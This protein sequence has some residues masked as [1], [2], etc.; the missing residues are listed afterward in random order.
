MKLLLILLHLLIFPVYLTAQQV[1]ID[2]EF[3]GEGSILQPEKSSEINKKN[4]KNGF[5]IDN[6]STSYK[7]SDFQVNGLDVD[8]DDYEME[9]WL[10][11]LSGSDNYG[12]GLKWAGNYT[13]KNFVLIT[14]NQNYKVSY[15][16][17][18]K[19]SDFLAWTPNPKIVNSSK[20]MNKLKVIKIGHH[21]RILINDVTIYE[22]GFWRDFGN[23]F[24]IYVQDFM[25][26]Q[27]N[28]IKVIKYENK[29]INLVKDIDTSLK[30]EN[31]GEEW[32]GIY[33]KTQPVISPDGKTL[34]CINW[35]DPTNVGGKDDAN[36]V[37]YSTLGS[38]GKW[39]PL[40]NISKPIN[41]KSS[42]FVIACSPDNNMLVLANQ[43]DENGESNG[44]GMSISLRNSDGNFSIPVN[45][46]I[47][48]YK[49]KSG[50]VSYFIPTNNKTL[51]LGIESD[52]GFG[53]QDLHVSFLNN[54]NTWSEPL[55]MG[56]IIN[57]AGPDATPFLA[58]DGKTL[59]FSSA[60]HKGFGGYDIFV[61]RRLDD[62]WTNWSVPENLGANINTWASEIGYFMSAKGD[63]AYLSSNGDIHRIKN[64]AAI[65]PVILLFGKVLNNVT[66]K[67][68]AAQIKY[69]DLTE[70][71]EL[72]IAVSD[73]I[74]GE[75][76]IVLQKGKKYSFLA[77]KNGFYAV[78]ESIDLKDLNEYKEINRDLF[79]NPVEKGQSIRLN[80]LF[81]EV[82]KSVLMPES[83][84][85]LDN[86]LKL[87]ANQPELKIEINGHTDSDGSDELNLKLS[88]DR[89]KAV[90]TYLVS[91][92]VKS[93]RLTAKG[94]GETK[95]AVPNTSP[96]NKAINRRVEFKVL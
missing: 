57:S 20:V 78:S 5:E 38:D 35:N 23:E 73:E 74:N 51:L 85:E 9:V 94:L 53:D 44:G 17:D 1:L 80:N 46:V 24:A 40:K 87:L 52:K 43:Y 33:D 18:S 47:K 95:P 4:T 15:I 3:K 16:K 30:L 91:K 39:G 49:N 93:D 92:G 84:A 64:Q 48:N 8:N 41:N 81:F 71:K 89:A 61:S 63:Y 45:Q 88:D 55:N 59:F 7:L 14:A 12:Y 72:G 2:E 34:F 19:W 26:I 86:L 27:V 28:R 58:A 36:D 37:M 32:N 96:E 10:T 90:V 65:D 82:N 56:N 66:K 67:P 25:K 62:S 83:Y 22:N 50:Y 79:L 60:G 21:F 70:N 42:N 6:N 31:I 68:M 54:D 11:H 77:E 13:W 75:F 29:P 76:K 69:Y